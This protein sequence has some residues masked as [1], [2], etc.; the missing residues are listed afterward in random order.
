M[1]QTY[2]HVD[3]VHGCSSI[4]LKTFFFFSFM[5]ALC[6]NLPISQTDWY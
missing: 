6:K 1:S 4:R 3:L 2:V 5:R